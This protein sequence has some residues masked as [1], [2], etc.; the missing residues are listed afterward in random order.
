VLYDG[1]WKQGLHSGYGK[2]YFVRTGDRHE[3]EYLA[4]ER[5]G[6]GTYLW[7]NG[8]KYTGEWI[9]G[10]ST[11]VCIGSV[12]VPLFSFITQLSWFPTELAPVLAPVRNAGLMSGK[13][14]CDWTGSGETYIGQWQR[15]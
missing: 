4:G 11:V 1:H 15:V 7:A 3:G 14:R 12:S 10:T 8:D 5:H 2:K 6:P 9:A 13:G